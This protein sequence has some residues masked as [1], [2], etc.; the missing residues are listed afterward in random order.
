[1]GEGGMGK[2]KEG[3]RHTKV[4]EKKEEVP[5]RQSVFDIVKDDTTIIKPQSF[6]SLY[7]CVVVQLLYYWAHFSHF[8]CVAKRVTWASIK[9]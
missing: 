1:M 2:G 5:K 4:R 3:V 8:K 7:A 6:L 9:L